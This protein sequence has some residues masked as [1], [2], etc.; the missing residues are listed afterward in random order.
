MAYAPRPRCFRNTSTCSI[1]LFFY[2]E[3]TLLLSL[4][5]VLGRGNQRSV[6]FCV[7]PTGPR[8]DRIPRDT[9][10]VNCRW[11]RIELSANHVRV[12]PGPILG[13]KIVPV[14]NLGR[15]ISFHLGPKKRAL[16]IR[17]N[18]FRPRVT[19]VQECRLW[20]FIHRW[21]RLWS[22]SNLFLTIFMLLWNLRTFLQCQELFLQID[23][24]SDNVNFTNLHFFCWFLL[25]M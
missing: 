24:V 2:Q 10:G 6:R 3:F 1:I 15:P 12:F 5:C 13:L 21:C 20:P 17:A 22:C 25:V 16:L 8:N 18:H 4:L 19:D 7:G 11:A 23:G 14:Q 9:P